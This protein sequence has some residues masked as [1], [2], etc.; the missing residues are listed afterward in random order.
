MHDRYVQPQRLYL[1]SIEYIS[2]IQVACMHGLSYT[3]L[4]QSYYALKQYYRNL[5]FKHYRTFNSN[6][7]VLWGMSIINKQVSKVGKVTITLHLP[8]IDHHFLYSLLFTVFTDIIQFCYS[9][10]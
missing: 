8:A 4:P 6:M 9:Q 3:Q 5:D 2:L 1:A 10:I 7:L